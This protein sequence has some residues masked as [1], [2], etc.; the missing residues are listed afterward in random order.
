MVVDCLGRELKIGD[1]VAF[2]NPWK[3][4]CIEVGRISKIVEFCKD[5]SP[6]FN[7]KITITNGS[8]WNWLSEVNRDHYICL[9]EPLFMKL[10]GA[11][12]ILQKYKV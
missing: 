8:G 3:G 2:T 4:A 6:R 7:P 12:S 1:S 5:G 10:K 11:L 9:M